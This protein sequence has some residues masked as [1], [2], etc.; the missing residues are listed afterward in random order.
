MESGL[1][2]RSDATSL[3]YWMYVWDV[4]RFEGMSE[5]ALDELCIA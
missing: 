1:D 5:T 3:V 4:L 2:V